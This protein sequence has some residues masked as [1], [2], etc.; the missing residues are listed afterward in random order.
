MQRLRFSILAIACATFFAACA[1]GASTPGDDSARPAAGAQAD[2]YDPK[3]LP[4]GALGDSIRQGHDIIVDTS[5]Y[6]PKNITVSMSCGACHVNAGTVKRGGS[7]VGLYGRFPQWNKRAHRVIT[8][9]DR[10]AECFLYSMNG[11]PPAYASKEMVALVS[12]IA[13]LSRDVPVGRPQTQDD[14]FIV[15]VPSKSPDVHH[16]QALYAQKCAMCHGASGAGSA[17]F[18]PLWGPKSFNNGAGMA[19]IDRMAGFVRYNMPQNAPE[20]LSLND[21]YDVAQFVLNHE[22]PKFDKNRLIQHEPRPAAYF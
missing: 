13:Y 21:A 17:A 20:S 19:H 10:L 14:R 2:L 3:S 16:G 7:F 8:L 22:R 11:T 1:H 15:P 9:Q 6:V 5:K 4:T 18:P 12:Y